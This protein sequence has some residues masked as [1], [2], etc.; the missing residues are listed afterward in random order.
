[1]DENSPK[2]N[3]VN[4]T[5][6]LEGLAALADE[7][8]DCVLFD[9]PY[10]IGYDFGNNTCRKDIDE[11]I[12]W[13]NQWLNE[14]KRVLKPTGTIFVYGFSEILAHISAN[15]DIDHRWLVWHYT[16]KTVPSL[17]FWQRSHE[18]I[19]C[20]WK[21]K[22]KRLFNREKVREP[23]T[24]NYIKGYK[25]KNRTR[26]KSGGRFGDKKATTYT[27]NEKGAL[28]R[29][30]IK[31]ST[32]AG[33]AGSKSRISYCAQCDEVIVGNA[34]AKRHKDHKDSIIKHPTQK[35]FKVSAR[36]LKSCM[37]EGGFVVIPF[38]GTGS[39]CMVAQSL[40]YD[41]VGFDLNP[42]Y[43]RMANSL[44]KRQLILDIP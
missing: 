37:P 42:D 25:G 4:H 10:N 16:N 5:D 39:E 2:W 3:Q 34:E 6:V 23:Y 24:D 40:K 1:M 38:A 20:M 21:N 36:L 30:V 43:V 28:P 35:P 17:H 31:E 9:P 14:A 12:A 13:T 41:F 15:T 44:L 7:S 19:L 27:V 11:Y 33:G 32:L 18:S 8:A 22:D 26:P 29:D